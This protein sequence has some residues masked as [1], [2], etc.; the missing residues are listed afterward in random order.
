MTT[1]NFAIVGLDHW[2]SA[3]PLARGLNQHP[4]AALRLI[5]DRDPV[6]GQTI[7]DELG[8]PFS[9]SVEDAL[10]SA[11]IDAVGC[12]FS[13]DRNPELCIA[14]AAAGKHIVSI[15]P[16]ARTLDEASAIVHAVEQAGVQFVPAESRSRMTEQNQRLFELVRS[17]RLGQVVS[18]NFTLCGVLPRAWEGTESPG[19]WVEADKA[20]GGGWIDHAIYQIDRLRWLLGA[21]PIEVLGSVAN[22]RYPELPV[23]DYGHAIFTFSDGSVATLEDT[24]TGAD[25]AWRI[26][27]TIN[28]TLGSL[29]MDTTDPGIRILSSG[30]G[31]PSWE[32]LAPLDDDSD[33]IQPLIDRIRGEQNS[34]GT[35]RDA[36]RNLAAA[37]A[38][39]D[40]AAAGCRR[41]VPGLPERNS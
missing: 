7:A 12:F 31:G 28:G 38:F 26:T 22:L 25:G 21:E 30:E 37:R 4:E 36:W 41:A 29:A 40:A 20:P 3:L 35:V 32:R 15:K 9:L 13:V 23:E 1:I 33:M 14:A 18:A 10:G 39:Y 5:V 11:E 2:Y 16:L 34:L 24:W 6:R 8:V 19:W 17:G 27:T